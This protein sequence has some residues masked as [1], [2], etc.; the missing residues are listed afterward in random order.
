MNLTRFI[1]R[2]NIKG[3]LRGSSS[4]GAMAEKILI[5]DD[6]LTC[7]SV[8]I[9]ILD[10]TPYGSPHNNPLEASTC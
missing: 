4:V 8:G 1:K 2:D 10:K 7:W 5:V 6:E 3:L 9:N